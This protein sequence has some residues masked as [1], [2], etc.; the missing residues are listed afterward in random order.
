MQ[1]HLHINQ[2]AKRLNSG[3][4]VYAADF[5]EIKKRQAEIAELLRGVYL[6]L[7]K[8]WSRNIDLGFMLA[9]HLT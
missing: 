5:D 3:V 9:I 2:I 6:Q 8:L 4:S 1:D 7:C